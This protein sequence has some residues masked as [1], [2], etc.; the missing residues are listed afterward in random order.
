MKIEVSVIV[1]VFRDW[2][3]LKLLLRAL[4]NQSFEPDKF[5][6]VIVNN[7]PA[8]TP[9]KDFVFPQNSK[10]I[11]CDKPGS[12]AARNKAILISIGKVLAFTDSDC[13]PS[14]DW[15]K[16][17]IERIN[18]NVDL[19]GGKMLFFKSDVSDS[20]LVFLYEKCFSFNQKRNVE[21]NGTSITANLFVKKA[22]FDQL[23]GFD[24]D[25]FSGADSKWTKMATSRGFSITYAEEAIV[26][27]PSRRNKAELYS[28]KKR[29][30]GGFYEMEFKNYPKSKKLK[31]ILNLLRPPIKTFGLD[32]ISLSKKT[33]L[34]WL[35]WKVEFVGVIELI[36]LSLKRTQSLRS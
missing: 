23:G 9:P 11:A 13:I 2:D 36:Q 12:Y 30:S 20:S 3:R 18:N 17:G 27:H 8:E 10:V 25:T 16:K 15:L 4:Q 7:A 22:V 24:E 19:V 34:F 21:Q 32:G 35:K 5:E 6:I 29:T 28:K 26:E 14:T 1:P 33:A 31:T